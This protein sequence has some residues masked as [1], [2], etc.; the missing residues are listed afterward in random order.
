MN[1]GASG[2]RSRGL[3]L[4]C[5]LTRYFHRDLTHLYLCISVYFFQCGR[6]L[7]CF[8]CGLR[9]GF[10]AVAV[11]AGFQDVAAM[12]EAIQKR[13][14]HLYISEDLGPFREAWRWSHDVKSP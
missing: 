8:L 6:F 3:A 1:E 10:E 14:S 2:G 11:V 7:S 5:D 9:A 12:C 4:R 13:C